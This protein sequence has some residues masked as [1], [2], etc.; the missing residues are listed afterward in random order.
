[1]VT[2]DGGVESS[3]WRSGVRNIENLTEN[4]ERAA[5]VRKAELRLEV[6]LQKL[7]V[8]IYPSS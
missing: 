3:V 1:M 4:G 2:K 8:Y 6:K 7:L 5:T